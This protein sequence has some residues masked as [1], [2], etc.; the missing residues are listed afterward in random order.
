MTEI[1]IKII[2]LALDTKIKHK[3][4]AKHDLAARKVL[5]DN[6]AQNKMEPLSIYSYILCSYFDADNSTSS[7]TKCKCGREKWEHTYGKL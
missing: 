1:E 3:D 4:Y 7:A 2:R 5:N 6:E